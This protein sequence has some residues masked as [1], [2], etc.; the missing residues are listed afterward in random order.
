LSITAATRQL[1]IIESNSIFA[2]NPGD[3]RDYFAAGE[4]ISCAR[5]GSARQ[6]GLYEKGG[7]FAIEGSEA[8]KKAGRFEPT[9]FYGVR[10]LPS[11]N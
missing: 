11:Q 4:T 3:V 5:R 1:N 7:K 9:G 6:S 8:N 10:I 2:W